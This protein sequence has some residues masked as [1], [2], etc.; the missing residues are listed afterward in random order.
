MNI[1]PIFCVQVPH[2][3]QNDIAE[4]MKLITKKL[5]FQY[6]VIIY[7]G[8]ENEWKFEAFYPQNIDAISLDELQKKVMQ[9]ANNTKK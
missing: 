7:M 2:A 1:K 3:I 9:A 8:A 5:R 4:L 6:H